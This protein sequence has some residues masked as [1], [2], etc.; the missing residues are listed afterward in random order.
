[1]QKRGIRNFKC[2]YDF[3]RDDQ[4]SFVRYMLQ[5]PHMAGLQGYTSVTRHNF[6][7]GAKKFHSMIQPPSLE[8]YEGMQVQISGEG[9]HSAGESH[10]TSSLSTSNSDDD[11][12]AMALMITCY[13]LHVGA[14]LR[15]TDRMRLEMVDVTNADSSSSG[16]MEKGSYLSGLERNG[17]GIVHCNNINSALIILNWLSGFGR[18]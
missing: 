10:T 6:Y 16:T 15:L 2:K 9:F 18:N 11:P 4:Q 12:A 1:M 5:N 8:S 3:L 7:D 17:V 13:R 14:T